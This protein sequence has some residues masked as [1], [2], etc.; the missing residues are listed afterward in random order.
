MPGILPE[1]SP[2]ARGWG[3]WDTAAASGTNAGIGQTGITD[4][5]HSPFPS[6]NP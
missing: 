5:T 6:G 2:E 1:G 4:A 3:G